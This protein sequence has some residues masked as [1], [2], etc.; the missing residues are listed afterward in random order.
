[1]A[2][3]WIKALHA[4]NGK[5]IAQTLAARVGYAKNP[6]KTG[7]GEL[8]SSYRCAWQSAE[9][10]FLL[11]KQE[12]GK[13]R[14]KRRDWGARDVLAYHIR[15]SFKP[16]E[17]SPEEANA[18]GMELAMRFTKGRHALIVATHID[19][20]HVHNHII[21]NSTSIDCTRKFRDFIRSGRA[22]RRISDLVCI[23]HGLSVI[24]ETKPNNSKDYGEWLGD[25]KRQSWQGLLRRKIDETLPACDTFESFIEAMRAAGYEANTARKHITMKAP[26]Q[27][28]PTRLDTLK[29]RHAEQAIRERIAAQ[30]AIHGG[31]GD[32]TEQKKPGKA[33]VAPAEG[34]LN[35]L[36]DIQAKIR[37]G[38]GA[39]FEHWAKVANLKEAAKTLMFLQDS[40][41]ASYDEL[42]R[43]AASASARF[44][45]LSGKIKAAGERQSEINYIQRQIG[46][47]SKT[48]AVYAE[49]RESGYSKKHRA[50]HEADIMLHQAAK[51]AFDA[52]GLQK[53]PTIKSLQAEYRQLA[54][55]KNKLYAE[56]R[57]AKDGMKNLATAK[58]NAESILR[59][60]PRPQ[61]L[62]QSL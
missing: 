38:M 50:E 33:A 21:F 17:V 47:Y 43:K 57:R 1:L 36:I 59:M 7:D 31:V 15:Q 37:Q 19:R 14:A 45:E 62:G 55:D 8:V 3:T 51:K 11:S 2:A 34:K 27:K 44:R 23:E 18:I 40:G 20:A 28:K 24:E 58:A 32:G 56:Y 12:Y 46:V 26:G 5:T 9:A 29:G 61:D 25:G 30:R 60:K 35:L 4:S 39:G 52:L 49:Y 6:D 10:E 53:L 13:R 16:G 41:I 22:V 48:R 54:C 42:E